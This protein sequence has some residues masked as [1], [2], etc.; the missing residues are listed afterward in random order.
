VRPFGRRSTSTVAAGL[1]A[2]LALTALVAS[3][4]AGKVIGHGVRL[5]DT[6]IFYAQ[7]TAVRPR[8][9]SASV[10]PTPVLPVKVQ[11]SLVCQKPNRADP[12]MQIAA[13]ATSG[14]TTVRGAGTVKLELPHHTTPPNCVATVYATLGGKGNL[15]LRLLQT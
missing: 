6:K 13:G 7:G 15:V 2:A 1:S 3:A 12:A 14:V 8:T 9:V 4:A 10:V 11:W 5:K